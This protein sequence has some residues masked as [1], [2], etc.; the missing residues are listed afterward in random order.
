M[1]LPPRYCN[2]HNATNPSL[3]LSAR[4]THY[5]SQRGFTKLR[6]A[7]LD[8]PDALR[9]GCSR[10]VFVAVGGRDNS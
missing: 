4:Y 10:Y 9:L 1:M 3:L 7:W 8:P 6:E 2:N 5:A